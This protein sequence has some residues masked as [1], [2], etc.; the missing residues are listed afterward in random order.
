MPI[1]GPRNVDNVNIR[2]VEN[3]RRRVDDRMVRSGETE[4]AMCAAAVIGRQFR[5][6]LAVMQTE[7]QGW[8]TLGSVRGE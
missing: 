4:D 8:C 5:L 3:D 1:S 6:A 2:A 7:L